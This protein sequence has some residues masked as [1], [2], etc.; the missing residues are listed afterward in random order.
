MKEDQTHHSCKDL[1]DDL[2]PPIRSPESYT[3]SQQ[4]HRCVTLPDS[5]ISEK[6]GGEHGAV[7]GIHYKNYGMKE[8]TNISA[9]TK[10]VPAL[11]KAITN[12]DKKPSQLY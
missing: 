9:R 6:I 10:S 12:Y 4:S 2:F 1:R 11:T 8:A 5:G 3:K 7:M